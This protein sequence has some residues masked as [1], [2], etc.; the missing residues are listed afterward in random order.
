MLEGHNMKLENIKEK[1]ERI[2]KL[3]VI[4]FAWFC[5]LLFNGC[6]KSNENN[7][8]ILMFRFPL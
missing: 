8:I 3:L 6:A 7:Q 5:L 4:A 2:S 1:T